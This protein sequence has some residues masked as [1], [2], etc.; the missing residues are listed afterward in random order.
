[1]RQRPSPTGFYIF[2]DPTTSCAPIQSKVVKAAGDHFQ[3]VDNVL[4]RP[5]YEVF[6]IT[7]PI[8]FHNFA[9]NVRIVCF[10]RPS[11]A[12]DR[13]RPFALWTS[14]AVRPDIRSRRLLNRRLIGRWG[15]RRSKVV[16]RLRAIFCARRASRLPT[17]GFRQGTR[18]HFGHAQFLSAAGRNGAPSRRRGRRN[19]R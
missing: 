17:N 7:S 1:M 12:G 3:D 13:V 4:S 9:A 5:I 8:T 2:P 14:V 18:F 16:V 19:R 11:A 10:L 6:G 15:V